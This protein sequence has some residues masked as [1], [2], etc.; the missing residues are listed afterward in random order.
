[1]LSPKYMPEF[2]DAVMTSTSAEEFLEKLMLGRLAPI[3]T[4]HG[5]VELSQ[6]VMLGNSDLDQMGVNAIGVR[7]RLLR[8]VDLLREKRPHL[9]G[10]DAAMANGGAHA[11]ASSG[12]PSAMEG[13]TKTG[14][15]GYRVNS[16][17]SLYIASTVCKP[18]FLEVCFGVSLFVHDLIER[19][20][21]CLRSGTPTPAANGKRNPFEKF[22]PRQIFSFKRSRDQFEGE[23]LP[24][25]PHAPPVPLEIAEVPSE[26]DIRQCITNLH[27]LAGFSPGCLVV[28]LIYIERL[29]RTSGAQMLASTWQ[30]MLL[31]AVIVAQKVW[32]DKRHMNAGFVHICPDLTVPRLNQLEFDFLTQ[33][34]YHVGVR[35]AVYTDWYFKICSL[36]ERSNLSMKP[37][38]AEEASH[39]ELQALSFEENLRA[40]CKP[41][42]NSA[43]MPGEEPVAVNDFSRGRAVIS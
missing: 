37:L 10:G 14:Q 15:E 26:E 43:P 36:C 35:A 11:G 33:L 31:I 3:F 42:H 8:A 7:R 18:D 22:Q 40:E 5:L 9:V 29:R 41:K 20:E 16:T 39:L 4:Q 12:G 23:A 1:M 34:D 21:E 27:Q 13:V 32:E 2:E 17:S 30:P 28:S 24:P 25:H 38:D 6:M 19:G